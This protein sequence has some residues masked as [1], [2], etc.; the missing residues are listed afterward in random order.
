MRW[1]SI[2]SHWIWNTDPNRFVRVDPEGVVTEGPDRM[3]PVNLASVAGNGAR[4][5]LASFDRPL[6]GSLAHDFD[7]KESSIRI[8]KCSLPANELFRLESVYPSG[9]WSRL[10]MKFEPRELSGDLAPVKR[11]K[12]REIALGGRVPSGLELALFGEDPAPFQIQFAMAQALQIPVSE[13]GSPLNL[14]FSASPPV[15]CIGAGN[16]QLLDKGP[17]PDRLVLEMQTL[18]CMDKKGT[19]H[20]F[21]VV[22]TGP[23]GAVGMADEHGRIQLVTWL[24]SLPTLAPDGA[25]VAGLAPILDGDWLIFERN[26]QTSGLHLQITDHPPPEY[27]FAHLIGP[28]AMKAS[29]PMDPRGFVHFPYLPGGDYQ[30][31]LFDPFAAESE[32]KGI[33]QAFSITETHPSASLTLRWN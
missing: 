16:L 18:T 26:A 33:S 11:W 1:Q 19:P 20:P 32:A 31:V 9:P 27:L 5:R 8:A 2:Q 15:G 14:A 7:F 28:G 10:E 12:I 17:W 21:A 23:N 25:I 3:I 24:G 4:S 30:V 6:A 13:S 29:L 22:R